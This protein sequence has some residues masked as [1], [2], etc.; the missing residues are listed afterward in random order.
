MLFWVVVMIKLCFM[1]SLNFTAL[2][3]LMQPKRR[4]ARLSA[5][6]I[7]IC[8]LVFYHLGWGQLKINYWGFSPRIGKGTL[9]VLLYLEFPFPEHPHIP[10]F[11]HEMSV[12]VHFPSGHKY[13]ELRAIDVRMDLVLVGLLHTTAPGSVNHLLS[14]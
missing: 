1:C 10:G 5:V 6:S 9:R 12:L 14:P 13:P 11:S 8:P 2:S 3:F 4:S 7:Y